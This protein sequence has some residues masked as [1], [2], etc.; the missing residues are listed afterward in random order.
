MYG[1]GIPQRSEPRRKLECARLFAFPVPTEPTPQFFFECAL[2][3]FAAIA[4]PRSLRE[5]GMDRIPIDEAAL[6]AGGELI[7]ARE[8]RYEIALGPHHDAV[9]ALAFP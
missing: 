7:I 4:F 8:Y 1:W 3:S 5:F 6:A 9:D 2:P